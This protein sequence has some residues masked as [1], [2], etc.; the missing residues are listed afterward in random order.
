MRTFWHRK[1]VCCVRVWKCVYTGN[2]FPVYKCAYVWKRS[3]T[4]YV[5]TDTQE[6]RFLCT[7]MYMYTILHIYIY[8]YVCTHSS[9]WSSWT[10]VYMHVNICIYVY[11]YVLYIHVYIYKYVYMYAILHIHI[12]VY[13]CAHTHRWSRWKHGCTYVYA[14]VHVYV[15]NYIYS[16]VLIHVYALPQVIPLDA[17]LEL[18]LNTWISHLEIC[19]RA[20][21]D[22]IL[23]EQVCG[24][25]RS[26]LWCDSFVSETSTRS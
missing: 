6:T 25:T 23:R 5:H 13:I 19:R 8:V 20:T 21:L 15:Y 22:L 24:V 10:H 17:W 18:M 9:W 1:E 14:H 7:Y 2:V 11:I 26:C 12:Y 4:S 3:H 16:H